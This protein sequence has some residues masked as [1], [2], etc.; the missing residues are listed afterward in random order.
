MRI[1]IRVV[2]PGD[3]GWVDERDWRT[4]FAWHPVRINSKELAW[5]EPVERR[6]VGHRIAGG[7]FSVP[8][9]VPV[10]EYRPSQSAMEE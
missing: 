3:A 10:Y 7:G 6:V 2:R 9:P 4:W 5:W 8:H 1:N